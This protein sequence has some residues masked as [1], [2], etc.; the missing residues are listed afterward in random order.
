MCIERMI[1]PLFFH[2][3]LSLLARIYHIACVPESSTCVHNRHMHVI[4]LRWHMFSQSEWCCLLC[5]TNFL[6]ACGSGGQCLR[7]VLAD[8]NVGKFFIRAADHARLDF[9]GVFYMYD[10]S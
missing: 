10:C 5:D 8:F 4:T 9:L 2:L 6:I 7:Q 3:M 1:A